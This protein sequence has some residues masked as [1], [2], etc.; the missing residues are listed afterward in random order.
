M[1]ELIKT[2]EDL[3][4]AKDQAVQS[5]LDSKPLIDELEKLQSEVNAAKNRNAAIS[6][7]QLELE[8]NQRRMSSKMEEELQAIKVTNELTKALDQTCKDLETI[9]LEA[10]EQ[11]R[12]RLKLKQVLRIRRQTL[13]SLQLKLRAVRIEAEAFAMSLEDA[14]ANIDNSKMDNDIK[15][16]S[17]EEYCSLVRREREETSLSNWRVSVAEEQKLATEASR[18]MALS[19]LSQV[20]ETKK[21]WGEEDSIVEHEETR[22][23]VAEGTTGDSSGRV[24]GQIVIPKARARAMREETARNNNSRKRMTVKKRRKNQSFFSKITDFIKG[25]KKWFR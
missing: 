4:V 18:N 7:L 24:G 9:K 16:L 12:E 1:K 23:V 3:K 21:R 6:D 25:I 10:D 2:N 22:A 11:R 19:R 14:S 5:W 13:R 8:D 20:C 17:G 15:L